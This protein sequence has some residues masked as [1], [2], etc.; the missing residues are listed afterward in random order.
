MRNSHSLWRIEAA[1][2]ISGHYVH[3]NITSVAIGGSSSRGIADPYSD[4]ELGVYWT[5]R[6]SRHLRDLAIQGLGA[7][8]RYRS[9][10]NNHAG[11]S[12]IDVYYVGAHGDLKIDVLHWQVGAAQEVIDDV[13]RK[14]DADIEK[15]ELIAAIQDSIAFADNGFLSAAQRDISQY[16]D[17]LQTHMIEANLQFGPFHGPDMLIARPSMFIEAHDMMLQYQRKILN[18]L[19]GLNRLYHPGDHKWISYMASKMPLKPY[20]LEPRLQRMLKGTPK[21]GWSDFAA[22]MIETRSLLEHNAPH[23]DLQPLDK[24]FI[25]RREPV[26]SL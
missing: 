4:I 25:V 8:V 14:Y 23:I 12:A 15:Q 26:H 22:L 16:P 7:R 5:R 13:I 11:P 3:P 20:E 17:Q 21:Q 6:P 19:Y 2:E 9:D 10:Q 1:R 18:I 24:W